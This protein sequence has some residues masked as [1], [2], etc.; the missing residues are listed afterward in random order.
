VECIF[1]KIENAELENEL[2][3]AIFEKFLVNPGHLLIIRK[4]YVVSL[5]ETTAAERTALFEFH[6]HSKVEKKLPFV[7]LLIYNMGN[8]VKRR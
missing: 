3:Q 8:F 1:C 2:T 5:F 4:C 7:S 6:N